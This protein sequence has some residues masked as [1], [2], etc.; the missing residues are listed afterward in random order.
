MDSNEG[1]GAKK[2]VC[3]GGGAW[4]TGP[5]VPSPIIVFVKK[6]V[7]HHVDSVCTCSELQMMTTK[8]SSI[9]LIRVRRKP[10][11]VTEIIYC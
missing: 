4:P 5:L 9:R 11:V 6:T 3:V 8:C 10:R 7:I 2:S 1:V